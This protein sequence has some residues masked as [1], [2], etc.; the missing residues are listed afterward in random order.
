MRKPGL[1]RRELL[2]RAAMLA[3]ALLLPLPSCRPRC[4]PSAAA[5][6]AKTFDARAWA[7]VDA[8]SSRII[9]TDDLP[10]AHEANVVG[11]IDAQLAQ[12]HFAVFK[13]E[14]VAGLAALD[15]VAAEKHGARFADNTPAQQDE[16][17]AAIQAG[18]GSSGAFSADHFFQVLFTLT[19]EG[20]LSDPVHGGN[21]D[22]AGWKVIGF[23]PE[24]PRPHGAG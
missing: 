4:A 21:K 1:D 22:Q 14:F 7:A 17:L 15:L 8:A 9:P 18:E 10:G 13:R 16:V 5:P 12:P 19:L 11:F 2:E 23:V 6:A 3:G 24:E 20:F